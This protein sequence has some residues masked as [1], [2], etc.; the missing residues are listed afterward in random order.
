MGKPDFH[1][2]YPDPLDAECCEGYWDGRRHDSPEPSGNRHP[3]YIHGF[4]NGREDA[5]IAE[6]CETAQQRRM[7]WELIVATCSDDPDRA[8]QSEGE[9]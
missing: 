6:R 8:T 2:I 7:L 5:G 3:A 1:A 4:R 9:A